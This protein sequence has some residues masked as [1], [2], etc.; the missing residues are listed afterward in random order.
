MEFVIADI[1]HNLRQRLSILLDCGVMVGRPIVLPRG[2]VSEAIALR[3]NRSSRFAGEGGNFNS[4]F[5][6][7]RL[8]MESP[9]L[10]R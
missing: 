5:S 8:I 1:L 7:R 3:S 6:S 10:H 4:S 2:F 9:F